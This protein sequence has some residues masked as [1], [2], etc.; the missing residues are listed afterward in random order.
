MAVWMIQPG[1]MVAPRVSQDRSDA[2]ISSDWTL[3]LIPRPAAPP[4]RFFGRLLYR[5]R[6]GAP[7]NIFIALWQKRK[8]GYVLQHSLVVPEPSETA[9]HSVDSLASAMSVLEGYCDAL[10]GTEASEAALDP[11]PIQRLDDA[12]RRQSL[13]S[14]A[15]H[16]RTLAGLAL[17]AW[18]PWQNDP[19][20]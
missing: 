18:E 10:A 13:E 11:D 4:L 9:T 7:L 2:S 15:N 14:R 16:F 12:L 3:T 8:T 1:V 17:A 19:R 6:M 20:R 5:K